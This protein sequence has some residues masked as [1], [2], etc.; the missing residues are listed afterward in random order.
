[1]MK[2]LTQAFLLL[3]NFLQKPYLLQ[4]CTLKIVGLMEEI[5]KQTPQS[6]YNSVIGKLKRKIKH[7]PVKNTGIV[8]SN[9]FL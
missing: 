2:P 3:N 9:E 4:T 1:M 6:L 5:L 7:N 8:T